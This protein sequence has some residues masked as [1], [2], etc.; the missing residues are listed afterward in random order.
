MMM[1][2][3][4]TATTF[5]AYTAALFEGCFRVTS[6]IKLT[7]DKVAHGQAAIG[8]SLHLLEEAAL[9]VV[10]PKGHPGLRVVPVGPALARAALRLRA[11][12]A[13]RPG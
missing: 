3:G 6:R 12:R 2:S 7:Q 5:P 9:H 1:N 11:A 13:T 10:P 8:R 4:S